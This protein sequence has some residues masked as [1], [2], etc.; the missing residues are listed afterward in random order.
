MPN[1]NLQQTTLVAGATTDSQCH[2]QVATSTWA[3]H[4]FSGDWIVTGSIQLRHN[5]TLFDASRPDG[6]SE[7]SITRTGRAVE[8]TEPAERSWQITSLQHI[9]P[10]AA[11]LVPAALSP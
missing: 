1:S 10:P 9:A 6:M 8:Q 2:K 7:P 11:A 4:I 5:L 3:G